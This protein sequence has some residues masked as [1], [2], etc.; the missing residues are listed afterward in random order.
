[1]SP[2]EVFPAIA[3]AGVSSSAYLQALPSR[4]ECWA[5]IV[6]TGGLMIAM[7]PVNLKG[8]GSTELAQKSGTKKNPRCL[9]GDSSSVNCWDWTKAIALPRVPLARRLILFPLGLTRGLGRDALGLSHLTCETTGTV[10]LHQLDQP[11]FPCKPKLTPAAHGVKSDSVPRSSVR[12]LENNDGGIVR[13]DQTAAG[14]Q[15]EA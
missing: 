12:P 9:C 6:I 14:N 4:A 11:P 13:V 1:M 5:K 10:N 7:P 2:A 15:F 3:T 8:S